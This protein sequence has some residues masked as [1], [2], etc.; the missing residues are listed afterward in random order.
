L[1]FR[2][3]EKVIQEAA[4]SPLGNKLFRQNLFSISTKVSNFTLYSNSIKSLFIIYKGKLKLFS[5]DKFIYLF[6]IDLSATHRRLVSIVYGQ[7]VFVPISLINISLLWL[8]KCTVSFADWA[9]VG[10]IWWWPFEKSRRFIYISH[11][12]RAFY[13]RQQEKGRKIVGKQNTRVKKMIKYMWNSV[14]KWY[15]CKNWT[16][17]I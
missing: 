1:D 8:D 7:N 17:S 3:I 15:I 2:R 5:P 14:E 6:I 13:R 11:K 4:Q 12:Q 16:L 10:I 9:C